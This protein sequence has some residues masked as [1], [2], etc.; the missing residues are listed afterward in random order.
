MSKAHTPTENSKMQNEN[1]KTP[2]KTSIA[3]RLL[4]NLGRAAGVTTDLMWLNR[5]LGSQSCHF[6]KKLCKQKD[7]HSKIIKYPPYRKRDPTANP[8][9]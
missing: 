5:F 1:T 3:Q 8:R 6:S 9:E 7:L 4:I 2:P